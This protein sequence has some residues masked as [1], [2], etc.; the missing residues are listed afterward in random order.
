MTEHQEAPRYNNLGASLHN[1]YMAK[2]KARIGVG[3]VTYHR[4]EYFRTAL[5]SV[6]EHLSFVD[7]VVAYHDG[8]LVEAQLGYGYDPFKL[9]IG[10]TNNGVAFAKNYLLKYLM[11]KGCDFIFLMEDDMEITNRKAV[12]GYLA[13]YKM[14]GVPHLNF[15]GHGNNCFRDPLAQKGPLLFWPNAVGAWSFYTKD[16][17][18]KVG[19]MDENFHNAY[20]H[21]EHSWR[22]YKD[23]F[24]YGLWPDVMG[25]EEWIRPQKDAIKNSSIRKDEEKWKD[26]IRK[27]LAYWRAKDPECPVE[28]PILD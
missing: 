9:A 18:D 11:D 6:E 14:T 1:G 17:I 10:A 22:I 27:S 16:I 28:D 12:V 20:E 23:Y 15:H 3:I 8:P 4:P 13:A 26:N 24:N 19:L 21:I 5:K 7:E 25:S 2:E